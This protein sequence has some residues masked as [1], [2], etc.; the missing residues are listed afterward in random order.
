MDPSVIPALGG[1]VGLLSVA[2]WLVISFMKESANQ[3]KERVAELAAVKKERADE[4]AA[5]KNDM[6]EVK[7]EHI[8][9]MLQV[10]GLIS[11][12][13]RSGV[14]IPDSLLRGAPDATN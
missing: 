9:C 3:R 6:K 11:V 14:P 5:L 7:A 2:G 10:N 1:T 8:A 12:L 13:Q 4:I